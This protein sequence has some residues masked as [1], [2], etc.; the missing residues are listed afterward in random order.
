MEGKWYFDE[1]FL[2][3]QFG[4]FFEYI[5][6]GVILVVQ[7]LEYVIG[8]DFVVFIIKYILVFLYMKF[9]G[10]FFDVINF[11]QYSI[12]YFDFIIELFFYLLVI[13]FD[14]GL[15]IFS[16]DFSLYL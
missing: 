5:N 4:M 14:G 10:W 7:V 16:V 11:V 3:R 12:M 15:F 9:F 8:E 6:I 2:E 1:G 13:Y